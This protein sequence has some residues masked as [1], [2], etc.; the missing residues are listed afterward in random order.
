MLQTKT[1]A[2]SQTATTIG[3]FS[4]RLAEYGDWRDRLVA[5]I[6]AYQS[7][8]QQEGIA[9]AEDELRIYELLESLR[10]DKLFVAM[11]AEFSRGKT[12]LINAIF[13]AD[14]KRRLLPSTA[15]RTTMCPTEIQYKEG[16]EPCI[17]L[18]PIETRKSALT[19]TEYKRAPVNWSSLPLNTESA[20]EMAAALQE[21]VKTKTVSVREAEALGLYHLNGADNGPLQANDTVEIPMWRHAVIDYPHPLL[22]KGLVVLDTPGLNALGAEP[23]LTLNMLPKAHAVLF[24]LAA[25]TGVTKTDLDVWNNH[26][27]VATR[28]RDDGRIAVLNKIDTLWDEL[29]QEDTVD[30]TI[31]RQAKETSRILGIKQENVFPV[32]AQKGLL[33]KVKN[34]NILLNRSGLTQLEDK[35]SGDIISSKQELVRQKVVDEIGGMIEATAVMIRSRLDANEKEMSDLQA[36]RGKSHDVLNEMTTRLREQKLI[37]GKEVESFEITRRML[38]DQVKVLLSHMSMKSFDKLIAE[39]R[40]VMKESWTTQGL[41]RGM[42]ACFGGATKR[43][44]KVNK[45]TRQIR[46]LIESIYDKFHTEHGLPKIRPA[47]FSVLPFRSEFQQLERQA[48]TFRNSTGMLITEQHFVVK[49]F[50]ITL[51]SRAR[52][53]F[54]ECNRATRAWAKAVL[55]PIYTQIREHKIMIDRRLE[56][57]EKIQSNHAHLGQRIKELEET[58]GKLKAQQEMIRNM[59]ERIRQPLTPHH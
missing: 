17:K 25:D 12:E 35:L 26:I 18:L 37:Y 58:I 15:G 7:W 14:H 34:D 43:M 6:C 28:A 54:E 47:R 52:N 48:E 49:K 40:Q 1:Q 42:S 13:F 21:I 50:F 41:K 57:L 4:Q 45:E 33:G 55:T 32:S 27:C 9:E 10:T 23:E 46:T 11:V 38:T 5:D 24:V 16:Q 44:E 29:Q 51:V 20:T 19:I 31:V 8:L 2:G 30:A 39:T 22:K 3:A 36:V 56:N 53:I 59:K